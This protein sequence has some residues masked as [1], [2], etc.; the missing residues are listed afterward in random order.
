MPGSD[1]KD[2]YA[3]LR[4]TADERAKLHVEGRSANRS[5]SPEVA[6]IAAK[7]MDHED[8]NVRA[9]AAS[10]LNQVVE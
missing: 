4:R 5:T 8:P 2:R 7:Y 9:L 10:A 1:L 3:G 6:A